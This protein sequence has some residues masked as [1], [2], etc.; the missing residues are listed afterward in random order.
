M[1]TLTTFFLVILTSIIFAVQAAPSFKTVG[2]SNT[3]ATAFYF[4]SL[5]SYGFDSYDKVQTLAR[6]TADHYFCLYANNST[7]PLKTN[8]LPISSEI[9]LKMMFQCKDKFAYNEQHLSA[10]TV[11]TTVQG[12]TGI[13]RNNNYVYFKDITRDTIIYIKKAGTVL[14]QNYDAY[15]PNETTVELT[16]G[17]TFPTE[18][19]EIHNFELHASNTDPEGFVTSVEKITNESV[20]NCF[21][22]NSELNIN[23]DQQSDL[24]VY[25]FSGRQIINKRIY[26]NEVI[27]MS[28]YSKG[29]YI[30]AILNQNKSFSKKVM[31]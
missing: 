14:L 25:D 28:E 24:L 26:S 6:N 5:S 20:S 2:G 3:Y 31:Y 19:N 1:K 13:L 16:F 18:V 17:F 27:N 7:T 23:V 29:L 30:V 10:I 12:W 21:I 9:A 11:L 22:Y 8:A 4:N 15:G